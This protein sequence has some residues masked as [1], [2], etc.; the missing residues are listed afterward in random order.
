M[1]SLPA[2]LV[3]IERP[4]LAA[5]KLAAIAAAAALLSAQTVPYATRPVFLPGQLA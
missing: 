1:R 5:I 3:A 2:T 4:L